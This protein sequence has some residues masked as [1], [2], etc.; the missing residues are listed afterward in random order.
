MGRGWWFH[1]AA[2]D[3]SPWV[4]EKWK[5]FALLDSG[6]VVAEFVLI[7]LCCSFVPSTFFQPLLKVL[8]YLYDVA[9]F[10]LIHFR[11]R[12]GLHIAVCNLSQSSH[13]SPSSALYAWGTTQTALPHSSSSGHWGSAALVLD[14]CLKQVSKSM[15]TATSTICGSC[16]NPNLDCCPSAPDFCKIN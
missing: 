9:S 10:L 4:L 1:S 13:H 2:A 11:G 15:Q 5:F 8:L 3:M 14:G 16:D 7:K 6:I 12:G